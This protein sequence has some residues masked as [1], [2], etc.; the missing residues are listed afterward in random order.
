MFRLTRELVIASDAV[1]P[2]PWSIIM[3]IDFLPKG[4]FA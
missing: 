2:R 1:F 3:G 4:T